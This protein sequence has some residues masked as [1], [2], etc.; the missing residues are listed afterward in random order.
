MAVVIIC[1]CKAVTDRTVDAVVASGA[2]SLCSIAD[3]C[4]AGARCGGCWPELERRLA[5]CAGRR[6]TVA[7]HAA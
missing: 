6:E 4:G 1:S 2:T 7:H 5:A 3:K